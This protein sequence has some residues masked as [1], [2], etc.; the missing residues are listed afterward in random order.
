MAHCQITCVNMSHLGRRHEHITHVGNPRDWSRKLTVAEVVAMIRNGTNSFFVVD[1]NGHHA[2]V[3]VV[4]A[5]PPYIRTAKD[6]YYT[7]NLLAL[8]S[9]PI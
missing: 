1:H 4:N 8:T 9:C 7:D 3:H 6:G 2:D 5:N